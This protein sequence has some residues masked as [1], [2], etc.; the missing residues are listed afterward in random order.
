MRRICLILFASLAVVALGACGGSDEKSTETLAPTT[1]GP[2]G[3]VTIGAL[4]DL[5]GPGS[6]LGTQS[7]AALESALVEAS[8]RGV[9]VTLDVRDTGSDPATALKEI[10]G[11]HELGITT[12]IGPQTSSE[13]REV[14]DF[15]NQNG[16]L[17]ISQGS[18]ASTLAFPGDA[19]YRLVPTD[20]VE[21]VASG[22]L[23]TVNPGP[24]RV[25]VAHRDDAGN[26]GLASAVSATVTARGST[27]VEGPVYPADDA[28]Y[29][30]V[31]REIADAVGSGGEEETVVYLA[32]FEEVADILAASST[33]QTL[34]NVP[35]YGGD[36]SAKSAAIIENVEAAK[37]AAGSALGYPSPLPTISGDA[38][39]PPE[40]LTKAVPDADPLAFAAYDALVIVL[41]AL[42]EAGFAATGTELRNAFAAAANGFDGVSGAVQLD[43]AGDRST[44]PFA[45]WGVCDVDGTYE[46]RE[47]GDWVPPTTPGQPG[48]VA[49][50]GCQTGGVGAAPAP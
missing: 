29:A 32:G 1:A 30:E 16:M 2:T 5:T 31:A 35:F 42:Q 3:S 40:P 24:R 50:L 39:A 34:E 17:V 25:V 6:T 49:Y 45:Y 27:V 47:L 26:A 7:R 38:T 36:G 28:D 19:L 41:T 46:W 43:S 11:L 21:G 18:T 10:Q 8:S 15:A 12:V 48:V 9:S 33:I 4:L 22:D 37:F 20:Q 14:L 44:M 13:A 23:I